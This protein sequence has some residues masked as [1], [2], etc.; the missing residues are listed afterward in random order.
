[1]GQHCHLLARL[2]TARLLPWAA[3]PNPIDPRSLFT[4]TVS[5]FFPPPWGRAQGNGLEVFPAKGFL[6]QMIKFCQELF[7]MYTCF[8]FCRGVPRLH[9]SLS[10]HHTWQPDHNPLGQACLSPWLLQRLPALTEP[11]IPESS[12]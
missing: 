10:T 12:K 9:R 2:G 3:G 1:M 5:R 8:S 11:G 4:E 6:Q 7:V